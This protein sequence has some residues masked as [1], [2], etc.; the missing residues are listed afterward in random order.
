MKKQPTHNIVATYFPR[1]FSGR[2]QKTV[3]EALVDTGLHRDHMLIYVKRW[4]FD[5]LFVVRTGAQSNFF[6][7]LK[8]WKEHG[9]SFKV[10]N[11]V[12]D[13]VPVNLEDMDVESETESEEETAPE[14][15]CEDAPAVRLM[16]ILKK[17]GALVEETDGTWFL[18]ETLPDNSARRITY[19]KKTRELF[20][21]RQ[22]TKWER[23]E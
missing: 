6:D 7:G 16:L 23:V 12:N 20:F 17:Y 1:E 9:C 2:M 8:Q 15:E 10:F 22:V 13:P 19:D 3:W 18:E 11:M 14:K 21:E 4:K 5:V